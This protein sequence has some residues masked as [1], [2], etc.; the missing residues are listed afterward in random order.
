MGGILARRLL[1][2]QL[3]E[4]ALSGRVVKQ[5]T[6][7]ASPANGSSLAKVGHIASAFTN[8]QLADLRRDSVFQ[9]D[10]IPRWEAWQRNNVPRQTS[11]RAI[12]GGQDN[13]V[14]SAEAMCFDP[15]PVPIQ[16]ANHSTVVNPDEEDQKQEL[17]DTIV[18]FLS[19]VD[20][21]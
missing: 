15:S 2:G 20:F 13:I 16:Y 9:M 3:A 18:H 10:L 8:S 21:A 6:L 14:T 1:V 7:I 12:F 11:V 4:T 5:L 19:E 17:A